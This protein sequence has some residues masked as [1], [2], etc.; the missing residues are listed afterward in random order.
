MAGPGGRV[1]TSA[2]PSTTADI[3]T[4]AGPLSLDGSAWPVASDAVVAAS[5]AAASNIY[6]TL[7]TNVTLTAQGAN[8]KLSIQPSRR[9][10][11][12]THTNAVWQADGDVRVH[13]P[14][15]ISAGY[16]W[17]VSSE[18]Y[19]SEYVTDGSFLLSA[20]SDAD[21]VGALVVDGT[22]GVVVLDGSVRSITLLG[23]D[24]QLI[25]TS[26]VSLNATTHTQPGTD[27]YSP[28]GTHVYVSV[29]NSTDSVLSVGDV[30]SAAWY[31]AVGGVPQP[32]LCWMRARCKECGRMDDCSWVV[33]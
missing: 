30:S 12:H 33:V 11:V 9:G 17:N 27:M 16:A 5:E 32:V 25:P 1:T 13:A 28:E 4:Y 8:A 6:L 2:S 29:S 26:L 15:W 14:V 7:D 20:D 18:Q 10:S 22:S 19:G 31:V 3:T 23:A 21:G 24:L